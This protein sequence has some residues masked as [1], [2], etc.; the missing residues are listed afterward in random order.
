VPAG[1]AALPA[2]KPQLTASTVS[3]GQNVVLSYRLEGVGAL[4]SYPREI[5]VDGL[6]IRFAGVSTQQM[7]SNGTLKRFVEM[8]YVIVAENE[9]TFTIP[10]Q[11][12]TVRSR[13]RMG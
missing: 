2:I 4:E 9:G 10:A 6:G 5:E 12:F 11:S 13:W 1:E 8:R 7:F 3:P